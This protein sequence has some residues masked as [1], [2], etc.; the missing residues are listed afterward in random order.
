MWVLQNPNVAYTRRDAR[1]VRPLTINA[2]QADAR[3]V[4]PLTINALQADARAVRPYVPRFCNTPI[5]AL[6]QTERHKDRPGPALS[7][8]S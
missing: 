3:A 5:P 7:F 8:W 6:F 2:L 4:R 1:L